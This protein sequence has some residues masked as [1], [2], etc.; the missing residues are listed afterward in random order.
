MESDLH[1]V[2][3]LIK[4]AHESSNHLLFYE[5]YNN[6]EYRPKCE[7]CIRQIHMQELTTNYFSN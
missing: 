4:A 2:D 7:N 5:W 6:F 1:T 3:R